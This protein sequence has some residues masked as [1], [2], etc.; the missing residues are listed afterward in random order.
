MGSPFDTMPRVGR[1]RPDEAVDAGIPPG[2]GSAIFDNMPRLRARDAG[3]PR[4]RRDA[5]MASGNA[6]ETNAAPQP[7]PDVLE[8]MPRTREVEHDAGSRAAAPT[9]P[10][11]E[12]DLLDTLLEGATAFGQGVGMDV[13]DDGY[14][15]VGADDSAEYIDRATKR[16]PGWHTAGTVLRSGIAAA[17]APATLASQAAAQAIPGLVS[18]YGRTGDL[19]EGAKGAAYDA[20][21]GATGHAIGEMVGAGWN[22]GR[23]LLP[24]WLGGGDEL[25]RIARAAQKATPPV[26]AEPAP[27]SLARPEPEIELVTPRTQTI[28]ASPPPPP[29]MGPPR[30]PVGN[31]AP[32]RYGPP[33]PPPTEISPAEARLL[34]PDPPPPSDVYEPLDF[35]TPSGRPFDPRG[36]EFSATNPTRVPPRPPPPSLFPEQPPPTE[37]AAGP[38]PRARDAQGRMTTLSP[39]ERML[40]RDAPEPMPE[41]SAPVD[42]DEPP[43]PSRDPLDELLASRK[44]SLEPPLPIDEPP[45]VPSRLPNA[46]LEPVIPSQRPPPVEEAPYALPYTEPTPAGLGDARARTDYPPA[47]LGGPRPPGP[48]WNTGRALTNVVPGGRYVRAA[49][50]L[51]RPQGGGTSPLFRNPDPAAAALGRAGVQA[52]YQPVRDAVYQAAHD[53]YGE[54][55]ALTGPSKA[56]AQDSG[57]APVAYAGPATT[58]YALSAVLSSGASGLSPADE[59]TLT[60]AVVS[61]DD[62]KIR[63]ADYRLR[64]ANPAYA[65][66]VERE[67]RSYQEEE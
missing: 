54:L 67:L 57:E 11:A 3:A 30:P 28:P 24:E 42:I 44:G 58:N 52:A 56:Y 47:E 6:P 41:R 8:N 12:Q 23:K 33:G 53:R 35:L 32:V 40:R 1:R 16:Q 39:Q 17:A 49:M 22:A 55:G 31:R 18:A 4:S 9:A 63:A 34:P 27:T 66:A 43:V 25:A 2:A 61:G 29:S 37:L 64:L 26:R 10:V 13:L 48:W 51:A 21:M 14:R 15:A 60:S 5:G 65:R 50:D 45:P 38:V 7:G 36:S 20:A 19:W 59:Q 62:A 46:E